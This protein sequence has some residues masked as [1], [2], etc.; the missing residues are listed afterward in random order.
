[1]RKRDDVYAHF[2]RREKEVA[3]LVSKGMTNRQISREL[4]IAEKTVETYMHRI[5]KRAEL[6]SRSELAVLVVRAEVKGE[7]NGVVE[8][9]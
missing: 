6:R 5:F 8:G 1:M 4:G 3:R 9:P 2:S 7:G